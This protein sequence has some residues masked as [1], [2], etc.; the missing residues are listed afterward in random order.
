VIMGRS[1]S[2]LNR[3]GVRMGTSDFYR[4]VENFPEIA[5]SLVVD[6]GHDGQDGK[7]LLF[8]VLTGDGTLDDELRRRLVRQIKDQLSPRH[9]PDMIVQVAA[10]PRTLTG[11]KMEIPVKRILSGAEPSVVASAD[12]MQDPRSL[13]P[14][15]ELAREL[16]SD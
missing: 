3:S 8:I 6:T 14:F 2:T 10:I 11:K 9:T 16:S 15:V 13:D 1:D 5:D 7:L 12:A 4:L